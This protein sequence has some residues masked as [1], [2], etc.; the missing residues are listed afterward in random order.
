MKSKTKPQTDTD[1]LF[2][3]TEHTEY[4]EK[5]NKSVISSENSPSKTKSNYNSVYS[6]VKKGFQ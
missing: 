1:D 3:T 6:V 4:T 5:K 2:A